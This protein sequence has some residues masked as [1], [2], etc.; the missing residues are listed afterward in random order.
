LRAAASAGSSSLSTIASF[1]PRPPPP[2]DAL[3]M[4]GKPMSAAIALA[5]AMVSMGPSE[6]GTTG[7]PSDFAVSLALILSPISRTCSAVG[8]MNVILCSSRISA[9]RAFSAKKP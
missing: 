4:M 2:A 9:K 6:P 8:P 7:M 1:M 3:T 5:S